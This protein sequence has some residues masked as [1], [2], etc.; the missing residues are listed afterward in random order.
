MDLFPAAY[1]YGIAD[2]VTPGQPMW[3]PDRQAFVRGDQITT[4]YFQLSGVWEL[5]PEPSSLGLLLVGGLLL[6]R[7]ARRA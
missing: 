2:A 7:R 6:C 3:D 4:M 1:V 5:V